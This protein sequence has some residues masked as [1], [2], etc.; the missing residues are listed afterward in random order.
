MIRWTPAFSLVG[1]LVV[2]IGGEQQRLT[3]ARAMVTEPTI[4]LA[5]EPTGNLDTRAGDEVLRLLRRARDERGQ[6]V[7]LVTHDP[8]AA[9]HA[10]RI[11]F[12][13]DG[14]VVGE[15]QLASSGDASSILRR[16]AELEM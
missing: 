4:V 9:S 2:E 3:I 7:V 11:V 16:L 5:D 10:D 6:T 14:Q 8:R 15:T 12:L 1:G 13:K